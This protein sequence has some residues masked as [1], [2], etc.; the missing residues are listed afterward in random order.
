MAF[1]VTGETLIALSRFEIM[2]QGSRFL[3]RGLFAL[4]IWI[5]GFSM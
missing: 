5:L 4:G 1:M 2:I 3:M